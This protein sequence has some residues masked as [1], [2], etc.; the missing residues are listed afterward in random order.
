MVHDDV[1]TMIPTMTNDD[2]EE[3]W[4]FLVTTKVLVV[5]GVS[6]AFALRG[7]RLLVVTPGQ[8]FFKYHGVAKVGR[9]QHFN[10]Q[11]NKYAIHTS[12]IR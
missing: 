3:S 11:F 5:V 1:Q 7:Q 4:L 10:S 9:N 8:S 12:S 2:V 6:S